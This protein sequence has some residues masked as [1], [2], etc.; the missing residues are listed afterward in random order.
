MKRK[1]DAFWHKSNE[2][3]SI[4]PGCLGS[5]LHAEATFVAAAFLK[6]HYHSW[7]L[8]AHSV[9]M[10]CSCACVCVALA[11]A[12]VLVSVCVCAHSRV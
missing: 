3:P 4:I 12:R 5:P 8:F 11:R 10:V 2:K 7:A 1:D 6:D 9:C